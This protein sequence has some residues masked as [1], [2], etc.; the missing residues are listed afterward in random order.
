MNK[1]E[2]KLLN[3]YFY[4]KNENWEKF[5]WFSWYK[6]LKFNE[7]MKKNIFNSFN[8]VENRKKQNTFGLFWITTKIHNNFPDSKIINNVFVLENYNF[9]YKSK[10]LSSYYMF[11]AKEKSNIWAIDYFV[12]NLYLK[13]LE[14]NKFYKFDY[15]WFLES[16]NKNREVQI[17]DEI[18]KYFLEN[19]G[20]Q[21]IIPHPS[22]APFNTKGSKIK[23]L[24]ISKENTYLEQKKIFDLDWRIKNACDSFKVW[25]IE[26]KNSNILLID[27]VIDSWATINAIARKI[28]EKQNVNQI[29][30]LAW[31]WSL[32]WKIKITDI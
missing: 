6:R 27:D 31:I 5:L 10:S 25:N 23:I 18:K 16:S 11:L 32:K 22:G 21:N 8:K 30:A 29:I 7:Y 1:K 3:K 12:L 17:M 19:I 9:A 20:K 28:I 15:I 26:K 14:L 2:I 13:F 24:E 4:H